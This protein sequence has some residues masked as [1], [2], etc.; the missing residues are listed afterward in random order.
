M[1][2]NIDALT[3]ALYMAMTAPDEADGFSHWMLAQDLSRGVTVEA[4]ERAEEAALAEALAVD[5]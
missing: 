2:D 4:F 1:T 3:N 5:E